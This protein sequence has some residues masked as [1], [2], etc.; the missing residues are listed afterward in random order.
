M[1]VEMRALFWGESKAGPTEQELMSR[2]E[3]GRGKV[4]GEGS[5]EEGGGGKLGKEEEGKGGRKR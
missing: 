2:T 4:W 1:G 5:E 3:Q